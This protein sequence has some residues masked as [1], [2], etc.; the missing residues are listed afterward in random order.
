[1]LVCCQANKHVRTFLWI[2][3]HDQISVDSWTSLQM[4]DLQQ[5]LTPNFAMLSFICRQ[6][7]FQ[8][9]YNSP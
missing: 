7:S 9:M 5:V 8:N 1:M 4:S 6:P 2:S 3:Q